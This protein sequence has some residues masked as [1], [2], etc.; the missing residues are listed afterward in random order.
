MGT[1]TASC[2][3]SPH[4]FRTLLEDCPALLLPQN[5]HPPVSP[6]LDGPDKYPKPHHA[7]QPATHVLPAGVS[8]HGDPLKPSLLTIQDQ[9]SLDLFADRKALGRSGHGGGGGGGGG[10]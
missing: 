8:A 4:F 2:R 7:L 10:G 9:D 5:L 6:M 3:A 1:G